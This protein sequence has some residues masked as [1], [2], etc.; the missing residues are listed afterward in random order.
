MKPYQIL[1]FCPY[2]PPH[3]GGLVAIEVDYVAR[4]EVTQMRL[5]ILRQWIEYFSY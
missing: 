2:Y 4:T 3:I 5:E 1:V